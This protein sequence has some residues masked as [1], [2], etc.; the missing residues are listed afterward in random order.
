MQI[1]NKKIS[2]FLIQLHLCLDWSNRLVCVGDGGGDEKYY[3]GILLI[4]LIL[5]LLLPSRSF[6]ELLVCV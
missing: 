1:A 5:P 2:L 3:L 4:L 6:E